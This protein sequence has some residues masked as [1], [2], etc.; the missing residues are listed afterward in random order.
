MDKITAKKILNLLLDKH[1][2]DKWVCVP[3]CKD[4]STWER[5]SHRRIDLWT[6]KKSWAHPSVIAYEIK[7]SRSDFLGDE[8][9]M[10]YLPYCNEF[11]FAA[12][13]DIIDPNELPPE[14]GLVI[15]SSNCK[16]VYTKKKAAR[17]DVVVPESLY[18]YI[19]MSRVQVVNRYT[20][21]EYDPGEYWKKWLERRGT[22]QEIGHQ[23][24]RELRRQIDEDIRTVQ[25][26]NN[27]LERENDALSPA[28][29]VLEELGFEISD[30]Y[31]NADHER[32][33]NQIISKL[34]GIPQN[35]LPRISRAI[36]ALEEIKQEI[37]K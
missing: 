7:I 29:K 12:P 34:S 33:R 16:R 3:E 17:R 19:L 32:V 1:P 4:G 23:I 35:I 10:D 28:K 18:R 14:A 9:W 25:R 5:R 36:S 21:P 30:F 26:E 6:M 13:K 8:K 27:R 31:W 11:Y 2:Q 20:S 37:L 24:S 15:V 22:Y